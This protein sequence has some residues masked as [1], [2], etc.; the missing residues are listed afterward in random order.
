MDTEYRS[1]KR[2]DSE[3]ELMEIV[4]ERWS[5]RAF[6][7]RPV[8]PERLR[9][10][11][12]AGRWAESCFNDQPWSFIVATKENPEEHQRLLELLVGKNQRWAHTAPVL[13]VSVART[14]FS[15]T[16]KP[17]RHALH[18]VGL[19]VQN[20]ILQAMSY[21]IYTHQMAGIQKQKIEESYGIPEG[22][23][24]VAGIAMGY[25]GSPEQLGD[26][27]QDGERSPRTRKE[28]SEFVFSGAF[29]Q[30]HPSFG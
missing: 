11:L 25:L 23:D 20:M 8:E 22:H 18:D 29:G 9:S 6:S 3:Q 19:A 14:T 28:R 12:E 1:I 27:F 7:E 17:N 21:G 13:M 30:R 24:A 10:I 26:E 15:R 4:A 5:P 2:A 16:G